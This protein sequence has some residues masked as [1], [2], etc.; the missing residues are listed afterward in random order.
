[1]HTTACNALK[2]TEPASPRATLQRKCSCESSGETC[3]R[4]GATQQSLQRKSNDAN[5]P[6][7][8]DRV[9]AS[10]GASIDAQTR[11]TM[12][13]RFEQDFSDVR[14]HS[15]SQ[16]NASARAVGAVAYA[17]GRHVVFGEGAF[18]P[19]ERRESALLA[20]ELA[21]V[22][23][24]RRGGNATVAAGGDALLEAEADSAAKR[25]A[26]GSSQISI[27]GRAGVG[28]LR[29]PETPKVEETTDDEE[30]KKRASQATMTAITQRAKSAAERVAPPTSSVAPPTPNQ[31]LGK[32]SEG[33]GVP[34]APE[35]RSSQRVA[36]DEASFGDATFDA[37]IREARNSEFGYG[38]E[39]GKRR[40]PAPLREDTTRTR[41]QVDAR[42]HADA[43]HN[44]PAGQVPGA[45][46]QHDTKTLDVTRNLPAGMNPLH[47][48]VINE[49][50]R[51]LQSR[52]ALPATELHVDP[53]G[54]GT[55]YHVDDVP[56]GR[57]TDAPRDPNYTTEHKFADAYLIPAASKQIAA[58][59]KRKGLPP[60]DPRMLAIAAGEMA[61]WRTSGHP[62][63]QRSGRVAD[64]A[65]AATAAPATHP[66]QAPLTHVAEPA[67]TAAAHGSV[68][69]PDNVKAQTQH[70]SKAEGKGRPTANRREAAMSKTAHAA[71]QAAGG[72]R[73]YD[74]Y[75]ASRDKGKGRFESALDAGK[76]FLDNTN[77]VLGTLATVE[78]RQQKDASGEQYYGNDAGDA[79]IGT[80]GETGAGYAVPG[81]GWDQLIN[82]GANLTGA[83]DDHLQKGRDPNDPAANKANIRTGTDLAADLT[84]SRM[85]AQ[86]VGAGA[87]AYYD[88]GRFA[89]GDAK[90]VDKFGEDAVRGKLGSILQP[91]AMAS[92]FV[93][94][95]G[96]NSAGVA[97]DKTIKKTEGT[98][99]KKAGDASGDAMYALGQSKEAKSGKYGAATQGISMSLGMTSDMIA[100]KSFDKALND[101]AD[102][103][104]GSLADTVGSAMGDAA[105]KTVEKGKEIINQD[106]PAAKRKAVQKIDQTKER[107]SKWWKS[108]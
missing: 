102:A 96:S 32:K 13:S 103:G 41:D 46:I 34:S 56:R 23:Q 83:A 19:D 60:L 30:K 50:L 28:L 10:P 97:L 64:I 89:G 93:G 36:S 65:A 57:A 14:L 86:T 99:L 78:Q 76:T 82:A 38:L 87:R 90:G 107:L 18:R 69:T 105:F 91:W 88:I 8:V 92:D 61:R 66:T 81:A 5:I 104:K 33:I 53:A 2:P 25:F 73:A 35:T 94:N 21:H 62:G 77:P 11:A 9:L 24:Q 7:V 63:T 98:T 43:R 85:F 47:P 40:A 31:Q 4:C 54:G 79:W 29:S 106:L 72:I 3:S 58:T 49:N 52:T 51:W 71:N 68:A 48:D 26:H 39:A 22:V 17:S 101:A 75:S 80:L 42:A 15:D 95:L 108:L 59:R 70:E 45:Q 6:P 74:T 67:N 12:E 1:M 37:L 55:R 44:P 27:Q 100:G 20:H 84:P 16:A